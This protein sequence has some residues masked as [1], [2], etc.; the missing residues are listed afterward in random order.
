MKR[1][2]PAL[3]L[4][5]LAGCTP[6]PPIWIYTGSTDAS[7]A[8][9]KG[10]TFHLAPIGK[11]EL[12]DFKRAF[13]KKYGSEEEFLKVFQADLQA[14]LAQD[15]GGETFEL[16]LPVLNVDNAIETTTMMMGGGPGMPMTPHTVSKEYC[17][18]RM[19]YR[20]KGKDGAILL[21]GQVCES[22]AKGDFLHPNQAKL[23]HAVAGAQKHLVDYLRGRM[24][25]ESITALSAAA[26]AQPLK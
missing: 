11:L 3:L 19:D 12:H 25:A 20:V 7:L 4:A 18:I 8:T 13:V 15:A 9:V 16:E 23:A 5:L 22:T 6:K 10:A 2:L 24:A 17:V 26:P 21:Q 14:Q 1:L